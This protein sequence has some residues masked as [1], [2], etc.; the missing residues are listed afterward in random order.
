MNLDLELCRRRSSVRLVA[1]FVSVSV[2]FTLQINAHSAA[3]WS[4]RQL[5][6]T[7]SLTVRVDYPNGRGRE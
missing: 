7:R 6:A 1:F 2:A 3:T 4:K 5:T